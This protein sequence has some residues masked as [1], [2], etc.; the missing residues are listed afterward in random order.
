MKVIEQRVSRRTGATILLVDNR[1]ES[2]EVMVDEWSAQFDPAEARRLRRE[3][4]WAT[5]CDTHGNYC[6]HPSR[7][8]ARSWM[9]GSDEW[10]IECEEAVG[11]AA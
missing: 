7:V 6:L 1:D 11:D 3:G 8:I 5:V 10:C 4:A 2:F 9:A